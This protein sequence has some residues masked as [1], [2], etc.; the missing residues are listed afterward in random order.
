MINTANLNKC[1]QHPHELIK[2]ISCS[3]RS[4]HHPSLNELITVILN[5]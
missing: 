2:D 4:L 3:Y 5:S 1:R